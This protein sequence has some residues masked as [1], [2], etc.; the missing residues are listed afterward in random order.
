VE[1]LGRRPVRRRAQPGRLHAGLQGGPSRQEG[2]RRGDSLGEA[3]LRSRDGRLR[4]AVAEER[5]KKARAKAARELSQH[6]VTAKGHWL[7]GQ[8]LADG[9]AAWA[10][11][12]ARGIPLGDLPRLP[13]G[14]RLAAE[15]PW[16]DLET[17]EVAHAGPC[18]LSAMTL[19]NGEFGSLHR[20]WIDPARP[21]KKADVP[22][23]RRM[24]P[25]SRG[26]AIRLWRGASGLTDRQASERGLVEDLV[27]CEGVETGLSIAL[28]APELRVYAVGSV[29]NLQGF[30]PPKFVRRLIIAAEND[31]NNPQ[32]QRQLD[33]ACKRFR[34]ECGRPV[35]LIRSPEGNDFND[36]LKGG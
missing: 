14:L 32:A 3:V 26:C 29:S 24:W 25:S 30:E 23:P 5:A 1:R 21:G 13:R 33:D 10:Y 2:A 31:W 20:T 35:G 7:A 34:D 11:F 4:K 19:P 16:I 9:D 8:A 17:G 27:L 18:I 28:M 12:E 22:Q 15:A 6:R 36:L